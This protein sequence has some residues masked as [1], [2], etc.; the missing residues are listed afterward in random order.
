MTTAS[1]RLTDLRC[2]GSSTRSRWHPPSRYAT[3]SA[4]SPHRLRGRPIVIA[5]VYSHCRDAC[6]LTAAKIRAA[7]LQLGSSASGIAWLAISV[8]P[9]SDTRTSVRAFSRR[10]GLLRSWH[11]LFRPH[12]AVMATLKAYG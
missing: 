10:Y 9:S 11:Y 3:S 6:P 5:F 4:V 1:V 2:S 12:R 8:D 7:Q